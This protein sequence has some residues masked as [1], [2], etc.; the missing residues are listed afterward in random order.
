MF[1]FSFSLNSQTVSTM[2]ND[3]RLPPKWP[4]RGQDL[5]NA[6]PYWL[7]TQRRSNR[8][9][10]TINHGKNWTFLEFSLVS[11]IVKR[12]CR[13]LSRPSQRLSHEFRDCLSLLVVRSVGCC[14]CMALMHPQQ[15]IFDDFLPQD[16]AISCY[17]VHQKA[18][19]KPHPQQFPHTSISL[20]FRLR[21]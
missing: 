17:F 9:N 15:P 8:S 21:L 14:V 20:A 7:Q 2:T 11:A 6:S 4:S 18:P 19:Q 12:R 1:T 10:P 16:T 5:A 13:C 3:G